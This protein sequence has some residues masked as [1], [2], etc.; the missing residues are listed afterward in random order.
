[1]LIGATDLLN[2]NANGN[3]FLPTQAPASFQYSVAT[4]LGDSRRYY[5]ILG[6]SRRLL[7]LTG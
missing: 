1:M 7:I 6:I 4:D 5:L 2:N 3:S